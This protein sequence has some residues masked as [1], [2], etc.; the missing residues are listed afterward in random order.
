MGCV[1]LEFMIW[2]LYGYEELKKFTTSMRGKLEKPRSFFVVEETEQEGI[3]PRL[4]AHIR[5]AFQACLDLLSR[6]KHNFL[7][8]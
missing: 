8:D 1:T 6:D 7:C 2:V 3:I 4:V 5:P